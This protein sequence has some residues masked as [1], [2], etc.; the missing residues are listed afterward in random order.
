MISL[1]LNTCKTDTPAT[2]EQLKY[3]KKQK[4][5]VFEITDVDFLKDIS[6][7]QARI[8]IEESSKDK[9]VV[10]KYNRKKKPC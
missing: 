6:V 5:V 4:S 2:E 7:F 8:A 1:I 10:F 9:K 3:L